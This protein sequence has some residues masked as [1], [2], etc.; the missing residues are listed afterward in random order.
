MNKNVHESFSV[1]VDIVIQ[2]S[3]RSLFLRTFVF[4]VIPPV[5]ETEDAVSFLNS[6]HYGCVNA[7]EFSRLG[8]DF[9]ASGGDD[10]RVLLWRV[11]EAL[12]TQSVQPRHMVAEHHSNI[13][14]LAFD[15]HDRTLLSGGNDEQVIVHDVVTGKRHSQ[16]LSFYTGFF[17]LEDVNCLFR[18]HTPRPT[19]HTEGSR[20]MK[21]VM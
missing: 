3:Y 20:G 1:S 5:L 11:D 6:G 4:C 8:G 10:R 12:S 14:C 15:N 16:T 13:F 18:S 17:L 9:L 2:S 21:F 19:A 7:V